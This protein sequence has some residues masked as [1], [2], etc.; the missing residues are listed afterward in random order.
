MEA[1]FYCI[2]RPQPATAAE[3]EAQQSRRHTR[4]IFLAAGW[5]RKFRAGLPGERPFFAVRRR[6]AGRGRDVSAIAICRISARLLRAAF[7]R[8]C[9][10]SDRA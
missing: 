6:G 9:M 10:A 8:G 7:C 3:A 4:M 2:G 1:P 5:I